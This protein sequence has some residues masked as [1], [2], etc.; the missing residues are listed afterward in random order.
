M[1]AEIEM[2]GKLAPRSSWGVPKMCPIVRTFDVLGTK[3]AYVIMREAF[4][5]ATRFEEFVE[6]SGISEPVAAARLR[7]LTEEGLLEKVPYQEPGQRTRN[8]YRLTEKG[9]DLLP[10]LVAMMR[11]GSRW[12]FPEGSRVELTHADCGSDVSAELRCAE[13]H[14]VA[15]GE[16]NLGIRPRQPAAA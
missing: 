11:W 16:L 12:Q 7:E 3:T 8:E 10:V 2:T 13:G 1:S 6:R 15:P 5:G 4:Y 9:S 14:R